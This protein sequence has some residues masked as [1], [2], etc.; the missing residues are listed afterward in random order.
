ME[1]LEL[2]CEELGL[3]KCKKINPLKYEGD[4]DSDI[5]AHSYAEGGCP[6]PCPK[7]SAPIWAAGY[8]VFSP[9]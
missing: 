5:R 4:I 9:I 3:E 2:A 1:D 8:V 6:C 7:I